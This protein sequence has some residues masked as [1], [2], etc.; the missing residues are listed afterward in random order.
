MVTADEQDP[1][2][3]GDARMGSAAGADLLKP[4]L[5]LVEQ[6]AVA[7]LGQIAAHDH[8][9]L[10][11]LPAEAVEVLE[12]GVADGA[13]AGGGCEV[14][15]GASAGLRV[16]HRHVARA[17]VH[18]GD[19]LENQRTDMVGEDRFGGPAVGHQAALADGVIERLFDSFAARG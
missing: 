7:V 6:A 10:P 3:L 14:L 17:D 16:D 5:A 15:T 4:A 11:A 13:A 19:V 12:I 2:P 1:Q 18:V 9:V 8:D